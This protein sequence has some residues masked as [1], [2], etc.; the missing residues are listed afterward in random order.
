LLTHNILQLA[1]WPPLKVFDIKRASIN[2]LPIEAADVALDV[3]RIHDAR[4]RKQIPGAIRVL[5]KKSINW[6]V[7]PTDL[8]AV[9]KRA[10]RKLG[11]VGKPPPSGSKIS[12]QNAV[13]LVLRNHIIP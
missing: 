7:E 10:A 2:S 1:G 13:T 8:I 11:G 3:A 4:T 9:A 6:S 12:I 5:L